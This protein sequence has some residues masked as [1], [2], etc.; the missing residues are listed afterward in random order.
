MMTDSARRHL[1]PPTVTIPRGEKRRAALLTALEDLMNHSTLADITI[2]QI[3]S[4]AKVGRTAFYFYFPNKAA[5]AAALLGNLF[6]EFFPPGVSLFRED[7]APPARMDK[8]IRMLAEVWYAHESFFR[9]VLNARGEDPAL[10]EAW[11][12]WIDRIAE[13][14]VEH[15]EAERASGAAQPGPPARALARAL[16]NM[17]DRTFEHLSN[18]H[19]SAE[20]V[21]TAVETL[22]AIWL[23][24]I[25][26]RYP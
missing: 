23:T 24:S 7:E 18:S 8:G 2:D 13:P 5:A 25:Y 12:D 22:S 19:A 17:N 20:D 10:Y 16:L 21:D 9:G 6:E 26:G 15:I 4:T 14:T 1:G 11:E 3:A